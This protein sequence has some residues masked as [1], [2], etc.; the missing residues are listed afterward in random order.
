[1]SESCADE[2]DSSGAGCALPAAN[3]GHRC[4]WGYLAVAGMVIGW[5]QGTVSTVSGRVWMCLAPRIALPRPMLTREMRRLF[6]LAMPN[7]ALT[8]QARIA[9]GVLTTSCIAPKQRP[10]IITTD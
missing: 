1:M 9:A 10:I 7:D 4:V 3:R 5:E 6:S 2:I 8:A